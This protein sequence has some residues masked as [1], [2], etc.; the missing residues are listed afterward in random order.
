MQIPRGDVGDLGD[1]GVELE[2]STE[3]RDLSLRC[4]LIAGGL[5]IAGKTSTAV[6]LRRMRVPRTPMRVAGA[7]RSSRDGG[8]QEAAARRCGA[9]CRNFVDRARADARVL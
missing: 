7:Q 6:R 1:F 8:R 4:A 2:G 3:V 5:G 9:N